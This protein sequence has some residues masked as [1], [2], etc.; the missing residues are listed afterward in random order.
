MLGAGIVITGGCALLEGIGDL[1]EKVFQMPVRIG[2][3]TG[4]GGLTEAARS[5]IH[6]TGVGLIKFG[7]EHLHDSSTKHSVKHEDNFGKIFRR[8]KEWVKEFF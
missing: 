5:P 8:M 2:L 1:A 6:A 4:F 7:M 3:P